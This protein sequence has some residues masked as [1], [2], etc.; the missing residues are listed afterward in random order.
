MT[1][2]LYWYFMQISHFWL[3]EIVK[4]DSFRK[5]SIFTILKEH[6]KLKLTILNRL[7]HVLFFIE[8]IFLLGD[9]S[10]LFTEFFTMTC[11]KNSVLLFNLNSPLFPCDWRRKWTNRIGNTLNMS[12][13]ILYFEYLTPKDPFRIVK[14]VFFS[15]K[16]FSWFLTIKNGLFA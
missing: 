9:V 3:L 13:N 14:I 1:Y 7:G 4:N 10:Q 5:K 6:L 16:H 12:H 2:R 15:K 11:E 8:P